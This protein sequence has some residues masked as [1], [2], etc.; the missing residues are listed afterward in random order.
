MFTINPVVFPEK[1]L[2]YQVTLEPIPV[3]KLHGCASL[4]VPRQPAL[5]DRLALRND[6]RLLANRENLDRVLAQYKVTRPQAYRQLNEG[7][8]QLSTIKIFELF[9][10]INRGQLDYE[11]TLYS[12]GMV[13]YYA[14]NIKA[15]SIQPGLVSSEQSNHSLYL[16][17][18]IIESV[19]LITKPFSDGSELMLECFDRYHRPLV[20]LAPAKKAARGFG[21][22][23]YWVGEI[24][25]KTF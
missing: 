15:F 24:S 4:V 17:M 16:P 25:K 22:L 12:S 21:Q 1:S 19:W 9:E 11:M 23:M 18:G 10:V 20:T 8:A 13:C 14:G 6:W 5:L 2:I 3:N 7:V